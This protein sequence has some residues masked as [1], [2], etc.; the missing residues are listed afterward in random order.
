MPQRLL[1]ITNLIEVFLLNLLNIF[2]LVTWVSVFTFIPL[3]I[4]SIYGI[5]RIKRDIIK[6]HNGKKWEYFKFIFG[7]VKKN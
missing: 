3:I 5:G 1:I 4:S 7:V 6:Y 2:F